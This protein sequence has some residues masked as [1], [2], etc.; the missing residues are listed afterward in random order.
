MSDPAESAPPKER[1]DPARAEGAWRQDW[2]ASNLHASRILPERGKN[3]TVDSPPP[4]VSGSLHLGHVFSYTHQDILVRQRRMAGFG[5]FY[6]MGWDDNGLPTE[7]RV[8]NIFNVRCDPALPYEPGLALEPGGERIRTVSRRNFIELCG[9]VTLE[10]EK[11]YKAL[12][13]RLG[14]SIDWSLEYATIGER[15]RRAAQES[16]LDLYAKGHVYSVES[17]NLWDVSFRTAVAQAEVEDRPTPGFFH[18]LR[19]LVPGR[20]EPLRIATTRPELLGACVAVCVHPADDR[21][22]G[23]IGQSAVTPLYRVE[24]PILA[25]DKVDPEKGTGA[26]MVCTFG[27]FTDVTWWREFRLPLRPIIDRAGKI[28]P[29]DGPGASP[30]SARALHGEILGKGLFEARKT[31][32]QILARP[33]ASA[34]DGVAPLEGA[35]TPITHAVKYYEKGDKP[36]EI[37]TTRQWFVRI[38]DKKE[39]LLA[40][41][42]KIGWH[43]DFM[44]KR[45][46]NWVEGLNLD[47]CISRQRFFGVPFPV[48][49]PLDGQ[50]RPLYEKPV[51]APL[52][53]LPVD[54][55]SSV[56]PGY[57]EEQRGK[58]DGFAGEPDVFDTWFTSSL[59]PQIATGWRGDSAR[60]KKLFPMDIRPQSHEIIRTW[61]FYTIVKAL[62]HD[63]EIPWKNVIVSGWILDPD[64]KKMSKSKGNVVTPAD[65]I[66]K[67]SADG[68]RYWAA[69]ARLGTD[70]A[71]DEKIMA[72]GGRLTTKLF[73]AAKFVRDIPT[74][75]LV[76]PDVS[77]I[78]THRDRLH[79]EQLAHT[80]ER[81]TKAFLLFEYAD[82]LQATEDFFWVEFCDNYIELVKRRFP[83]PRPTYIS[84]APEQA[85]AMATL[86]LSLSV[87]L[88]LFAPFVPFVAEELWRKFLHK[89]KSIHVAPWPSSTEWEKVK[90]SGLNEG[91]LEEERRI[92]TDIRK[93]RT[94]QAQTNRQDPSPPVIYD[95]EK[96]N[97]KYLLPDLLAFSASANVIIVPKSKN[98][99]LNPLP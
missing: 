64:R 86:K 40:Q 55:L 42:R 52:P 69:R 89:Q 13:E 68:V 1:Y 65:L 76:D 87:Q 31:I 35:P 82:A 57:A 93:Q 70:T 66:D 73:N 34:G 14:L 9:Q 84:V 80:V 16:F 8:Q 94:L 49:Y 30:E 29:F 63:D 39:Q 60:H 85:S 61:A 50:A 15:C 37:L 79:I 81:A 41:G 28:T 24:V 98:P 6:P 12:W 75:G 27:D 10:D 83:N 74:Y 38:L 17:P 7:R 46:E 20:A 95:P 19:F 4:T 96:G 5:T 18:T 62:L 23:L 43:P 59:T 91:D 48:W 90:S 47:W 51:L 2:A 26:V 25:S 97:I 92:L 58:P 72:N 21:V 56:P 88:R 77:H 3:F 54:P 36:L 11:V 44:R 32:A 33:A 53:G 45:Y 22:K 78:K 99:P 71:F 67:H